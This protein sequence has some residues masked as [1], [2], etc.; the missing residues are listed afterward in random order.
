MD[1]LLAAVKDAGRFDSVVLIEEFIQGREIEL[2][3]LESINPATP[4]RVSVPGEIKISHSDG[5]Y[6]YIAKYI[7]SDSS[8]LAIPAQVSEDVKQRLQ[9]A[10]SQIFLALKCKGFARIDFFFNE[11]KNEIYFNEINSLPGFTAMSMY[12][13]LWQASGL[14]YKALLNELI[15]IA[16]LRH[17]ARMQLITHYQ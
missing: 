16:Q 15:V 5:F 9:K 14:S 3:V 10:A 2:A 6:S 8:Q 4:P 12:P 13:K 7:D 1:E 11:E 17:K